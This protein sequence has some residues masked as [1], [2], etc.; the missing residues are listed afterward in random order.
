MA[1]ARC[2]LTYK[3]YG[4]EGSQVSF[5]GDEL[6]VG[7]FTAQM[8]LMDD[9][10]AGCEG[11]S[12]CLLNKDIRVASEDSPGS[13]PAASPAAQRELKWFVQMTDDVTARPVSVS[14]PGA[15]TSLLLPNSDRMDLT[16]APSIAFV[17][18]VEAYHQSIEGNA[19]KVL[20]VT[21]VGRTL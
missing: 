15:D 6:T 17:S 2:N 1:N 16:K 4:N 3:D 5:R 21:L 20:Y 14:I 19:V 8:A 9:V 11:I 10:V 13:G 7:N 18:A 12:L